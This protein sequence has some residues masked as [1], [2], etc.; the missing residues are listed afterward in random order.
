[1]AFLI[2]AVS[3]RASNLEV[4][5]TWSLPLDTIM[6]RMHCLNTHLEVENVLAMKKNRVSQLHV[7]D[8][9][10]IRGSGSV[11][12]TKGSGFGSGPAW[13]VSGWQDAK[14]SFFNYLLK[15]HLHQSS[16]IKS[17]KRSKKIVE[18]K[19]FLNFLAC[20]CTDP[21]G[22]KTYGSKTCLTKYWN[23]IWWSYKNFISQDAHSFN[24]KGSGTREA[25]NYCLSDKC[26]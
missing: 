7:V 9:W 17:I 23:L 6:G 14:I 19:V 16:K 25:H 3:S 24:S 10:R 1:M 15:V 2:T 11:S 5:V 26:Q 18:I 4:R 20:W 8:L 12:L 21:D 13:F 22:S